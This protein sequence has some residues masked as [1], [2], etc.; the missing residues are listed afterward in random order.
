MRGW[1]SRKRGS[2]RW[3]VVG[4]RDHTPQ[5]PDMG[6]CE[7]KGGCVWM[8]MNPERGLR[9]EGTGWPSCRITSTSPPTTLITSPSVTRPMK[10]PGP[11]T[12]V[13]PSEGRRGSN[14]PSALHASLNLCLQTGTRLRTLYSTRTTHML[15]CGRKVMKTTR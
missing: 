2:S 10:Y 11:F 4:I 13:R 6:T 8:L 15:C 3:M 5:P 1:G 7:L 14:T 9:M 12:A